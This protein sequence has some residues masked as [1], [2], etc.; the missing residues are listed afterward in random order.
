MKGLENLKECKKSLT[1]HGAPITI[2]TPISFIH[3]IHFQKDPHL[4][5]SPKPQKCT[6]FEPSPPPPPNL[7]FVLELTW[8]ITCLQDRSHNGTIIAHIRMLSK[9]LCHTSI[10]NKTVCVQRILNSNYIISSGF[11]TSTAQV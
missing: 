2:H 9:G 3:L 1:P 7:A 4:P 10:S 5:S 8:V 11:L 6:P